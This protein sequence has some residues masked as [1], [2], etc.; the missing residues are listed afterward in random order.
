MS[1]LWRNGRWERVASIER[2]RMSVHSER[3]WGALIKRRFGIYSAMMVVIVLV[4]ILVLIDRDPVFII[5]LGA[6]LA[7]YFYLLGRLLLGWWH[8][9]TGGAPPG[10]YERGVEVP[11]D[12][13]IPYGEIVSTQ[14]SRALFGTVLVI[15][16]RQSGRK[17]MLG[18]MIVGPDDMAYVESMVRS[19]GPTGVIE[20]RPRLV[21]YPSG[22]GVVS[23]F[24]QGPG[25]RTR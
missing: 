6:L 14:R 15:Q 22:D 21:V 24:V 9:S 19:A 11:L 18:R 20:E 7:V 13:F 4:A 12:R 8:I 3:E 2:G 10:L 17:M 5:Q 23:P 16:L 1:K 25:G